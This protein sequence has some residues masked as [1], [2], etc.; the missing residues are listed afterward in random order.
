[1][2][3]LHPYFLTILMHP[4]AS[5]REQEEIEKL[6]H[7]WVGE[8]EG[9]VGATTRDLKRRLAYPIRHLHQAHYTMMRCELPIQNLTDLHERVVRQKKVLRFAAYQ[10][11]P[12]SEGKTLKDVPLRPTVA[13]AGKPAAVPAPKKEKASI[14]KLDAKIQEILE[15]KML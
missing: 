1:M 7:T 3:N 13:D 4:Q 10:Q 12:R 11:P 9:S 14:E 8:H 5:T 2:E 6:V 15:E